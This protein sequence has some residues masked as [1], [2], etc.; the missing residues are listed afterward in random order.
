MSTPKA[1]IF[2]VNYWAFVWW[3]SADIRYWLPLYGSLKVIITIPKEF[4]WS[5]S[6]FLGSATAYL[7][8]SICRSFN[9]I[10]IGSWLRKSLDGV[11]HIN[12]VSSFFNC[13]DLWIKLCEWFNSCRLRYYGVVSLSWLGTLF[14]S[15][16]W[17]ERTK[18]RVKLFC[19]WRKVLHGL[20]AGPACID[21]R[22][23][24]H[25]FYC[26][27]LFCLDFFFLNF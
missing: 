13:S 6:Y 25:F 7:V 22:C 19:G 8:W 12:L 21:G 14:L 23:R 10:H 24:P 16:S 27:E 5:N 9:I 2:E 18:L 3:N 15:I 17:I 26:C 20:N 11:P 1:D 4:S